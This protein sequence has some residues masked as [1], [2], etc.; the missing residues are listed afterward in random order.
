MIA[1]KSIC[2]ISAFVLISCGGGGG[3]STDTSETSLSNPVIPSLNETC[4]L[5]GGTTY[6]CEL[7]HNGLERFYFIQENHPES[8]G[9]SSILFV[10]HGYGS[11]ALRIRDYSRFNLSLIHI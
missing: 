9:L 8:S 5:Y 1:K 7:T 3:G 2:I 4:T 11:T 10:L 6:R